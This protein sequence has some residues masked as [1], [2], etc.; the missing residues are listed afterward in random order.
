[1]AGADPKRYEQAPQQRADWVAERGA[2]VTAG[3]PAAAEL[4]RREAERAARPFAH[5]DDDQY[6]FDSFFCQPGIKGS[7][8]KGGVEGEVGRFRRRH[9]VPVP[10]VASMV[11]LY[12]LFA[13]AAARDDRRYIAGRRITVG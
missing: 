2:E 3:P 10:R 4:A 11:E 6:G 13:A 8:E 12:L 5:L 1:V 7:H 9:L